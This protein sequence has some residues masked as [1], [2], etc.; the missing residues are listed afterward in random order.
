[1]KALILR[2]DPHAACA[3]SKVLIDKVFQILCVES[4]AVAHALIRMDTIDLLVMDETFDGQL[5]HSIALSGE[6]RSP[7]ISAIMLTDRDRADTDD[8]YD[9]I[10]C[11]YALAG[12]T[13]SPHILGQ[14]AIASVSSAEDAVAR[15]QQRT[16]VL[17][18]AVVPETADELSEAFDIQADQ[19]LAQEMLVEDADLADVAIAA[20]AM[21]EIA[22]QAPAPAQ[23]AVEPDVAAMLRAQPFYRPL[24]PWSGAALERA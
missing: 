23:V 8:L 15:V 13:I 4:L 24:S 9:L 17:T 21:A 2:Q 18:D 20:P 16:L 12:M 6:R 3:I 14:L 19:M 5:T 10:P 7:Y 11:L 1:M 22:A